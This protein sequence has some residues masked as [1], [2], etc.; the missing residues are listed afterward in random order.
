MK[1][2]AIIFIYSYIYTIYLHK[3]DQIWKLFYIIY[4]FSDIS[5]SVSIRNFIRINNL[6][7][8]KTKQGGAALNK[9]CK[10]AW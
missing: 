6:A 9:T 1:L 10:G 5:S 2:K 3:I 4:I 7:P 8:L